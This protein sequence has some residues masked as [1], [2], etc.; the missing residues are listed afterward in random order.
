MSFNKQPDA[1]YIAKLA[2]KLRARYGPQDK[3]DQTMLS[4]Y[5]LSHPKEMGQ[6]STEGEFQLK[7]VDAGLVGFIVDQDVFV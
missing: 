6:P 5:K 3:L 2:T 4:H 7:P 1:D